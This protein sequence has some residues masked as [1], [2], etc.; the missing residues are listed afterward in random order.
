MV[1]G[2]FVKSVYPPAQSTVPNKGQL[3]PQSSFVFQLTPCVSRITSCPNPQLKFSWGLRVLVGA[4]VSIRSVESSDN[5]AI[6]RPSQGCRGPINSVCMKLCLRR[7]DVEE[8]ASIIV[9]GYALP[10]A[11]SKMTRLLLP[12]YIPFR[13]NCSVLLQQYPRNCLPTIPNQSH[14]DHQT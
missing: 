1:N 12:M 13:S 3:D 8:A 5:S 11:I 7:G 10:I 4:T 9:S 6:N 14:R 2:A